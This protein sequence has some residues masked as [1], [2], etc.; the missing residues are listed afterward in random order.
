MFKKYIFGYRSNI[1][2]FILSIP[3]IILIILIRPF[4][5]IKI[6][7]FNGRSFGEFL[8]APE[9][10]LCE[11][12]AKKILKKKN[13]IF[14]FFCSRPISNQYLLKH[15]KKN[16]IIFPRIIIEPIYW[17]FINFNFF[18]FF[19]CPWRLDHKVDFNNNLYRQVSDVH[20]LLPNFTPSLKFSEKEIKI[21]EQNLLELGY[22]KNQRIVCFANRDG[23]YKDE[24]LTS[25]RNSNISSYKKSIIDLA[26]KDFFTIRM[27][28]KNLKKIN[29][30]KKN[31]VDYCFS[32]QDSDFNDFYI[33]SRCDFLITTD[34][35]ANELATFF[36]KKRVVINFYTFNKL[37]YLDENYTPLIL[38]KKYLDLKT[39]KFITYKKVYQKKL[40]EIVFK[41]DLNKLGYDLIDNTEEEIYKCVIEMK[42]MLYNKSEYKKKEQNNFWQIHQDYFNW[43]PNLMRI[44]NSFFNDNSD[45]F[46]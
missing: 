27:G 16:F 21:G 24:K 43:K 28:R 44:S 6:G 25:C 4:I 46:C 36:R 32:N 17:F 12:K 39:K 40:Y 18:R 19:L 38:P 8:I 29:F 31:I 37:H 35:G 14:I 20:G 1:L 45:L 23:S 26:D 42:E 5:K 33:F 11:L 2:F 10:F 3:L 30:E 9:I 41:E 13:D 7:R 34:H 22:N 15:W